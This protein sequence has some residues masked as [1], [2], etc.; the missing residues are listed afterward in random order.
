MDSIYTEV[1]SRPAIYLG[2]N[3]ALGQLAGDPV[4]DIGKVLGNCIG[5]QM[6][7]G[8]HQLILEEPILLDDAI[9]QSASI[10]R[11]KDFVRGN[12]DSQKR[13]E[14]TFLVG[15]GTQL[16]DEE[17]SLYLENRAVHA[18]TYDLFATGDIASL[19]TRIALAEEAGIHAYLRTGLPAGR[20]ITPRWMETAIDIAM[21]ARA[22]G[23]LLNFD[24][25]DEGA[26]LIAARV[27]AERAVY[28]AI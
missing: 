7:A 11:L 14:P 8:S 28:A 21:A 20:R 17:L 18:L 9:A 1:G 27:L 24:I 2:L 19:M 15:R 10:K 26:Y 16:G 3:G 25:A 23:L 13:K 12:T 6:A 4:K 5:L 22:A